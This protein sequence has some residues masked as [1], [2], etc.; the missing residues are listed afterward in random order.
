MNVYT[1]QR[2]VGPFDDDSVMVKTNERSGDQV[3]S[4]R[5]HLKALDHYN[6]VKEM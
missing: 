5:I 3:N 1:C 4:D 6:I 2:I